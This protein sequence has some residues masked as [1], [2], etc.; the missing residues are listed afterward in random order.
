MN[1]L[2]IKFNFDAQLWVHDT[3]ESF[4][5]SKVFQHTYINGFLQK[6]MIGFIEF[7]E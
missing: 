5:Q 2:D 7:A 3:N 4:R 6:C 1:G